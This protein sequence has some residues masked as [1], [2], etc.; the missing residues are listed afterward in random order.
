MSMN[1]GPS[2]VMERIQRKPFGE[3]ARIRIEARATTPNQAN[4]QS[5]VKKQTIKAL[6]QESFIPRLTGERKD[7]CS[8]GHQLELPVFNAF[9]NDVNQKKV[10]ATSCKYSNAKR[11]KLI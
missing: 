9:K 8:Q 6:L 5:E 3:N 1:V 7:Y 11:V 4:A 10:F 2:M